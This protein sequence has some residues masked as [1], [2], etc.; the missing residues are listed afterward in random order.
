VTLAP[1]SCGVPR[2]YDTT[3]SSVLLTYS[4]GMLLQVGISSVWY[5]GNTCNMHLLDLA[6]EVKAGVEDAG[7]VAYRFNT[8]GVSDAISMGT[9]GMSYSLQS[10]DLI[11]DSIETVHPP[12]P[13]GHGGIS[14]SLQSHDLIIDLYE[15]SPRLPLQLLS[16]LSLDGHGMS[17]GSR[18]AQPHHHWQHIRSPCIVFDHFASAGGSLQ[19]R[20]GG[21]FLHD[22]VSSCS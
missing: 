18:V 4:N 5:E 7:M 16:V 8:I 3:S 13:L 19:H 21:P 11:A 15:I 20:I 17:W 10:R 14:W 12:F 9:D 6:E 2:A 22:T 1:A